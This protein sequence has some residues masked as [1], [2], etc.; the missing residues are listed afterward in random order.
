[1]GGSFGSQ[2]GQQIIEPIDGSSYLSLVT[3]P[4]VKTKPSVGELLR[5]IWFIRMCTLLSG[6]GVAILLL[7]YS[8]LFIYTFYVYGNTTSYFPW[9]WTTFITSADTVQSL[10][11]AGLALSTISYC[12]LVTFLFTYAIP[13][14]RKS[15]R[16]P[17]EANK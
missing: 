3:K 10:F 15:M 16:I 9:S 2:T 8:F 11:F 7:A 6:M 5:N 17:N 13:N 12:V 4:E 1:M 14:F